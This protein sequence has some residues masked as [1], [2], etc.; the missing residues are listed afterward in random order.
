MWLVSHSEHVGSEDSLALSC[1]HE[2]LASELRS[3]AC[4]ASVLPLALSPDGFASV[5][6]FV[7]YS[8]Q[9]EF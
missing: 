3:H 1:W 7:W 2:G 4:T 6:M 5:T 9:K 8:Y